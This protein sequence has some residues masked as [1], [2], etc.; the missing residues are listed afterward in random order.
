MGALSALLEALWALLEALWALFGALWA[1]LGALW[2]LLGALWELSGLNL[3]QI[4]MSEKKGAFRVDETSLG[5]TKH[6]IY[7]NKSKV[8]EHPADLPYLS[9]TPYQDHQNPIQLKLFGE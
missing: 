3:P 8:G 4:A 7:S 6:Y 2:A 5:V 1:L 9:P